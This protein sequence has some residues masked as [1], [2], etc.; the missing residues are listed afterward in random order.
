MTAIQKQQRVRINEHIRVP[1]VRLI[2]ADGQQ[3]GVMPTKEALAMAVEAHLDSADQ[4]VA[5]YE[6]VA[7]M[8]TLLTL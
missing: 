1:E 6:R 2:A 5:V 3:V 8:D 4:V 7:E